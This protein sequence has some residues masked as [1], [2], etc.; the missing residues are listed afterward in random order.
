M[1]LQLLVRAGAFERWPFLLLKFYAL[2]SVLSQAYFGMGG[3]L[4]AGA[5]GLVSASL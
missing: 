2:A 3:Y 1:L 4:T 5:F